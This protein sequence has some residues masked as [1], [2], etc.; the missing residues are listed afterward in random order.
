MRSFISKIKRA[1]ALWIAVAFGA[2][3]MA[4]ELEDFISPAKELYFPVPIYV[5]DMAARH[6]L[7]T[8]PKINS[9]HMLKSS[10]RIVTSFVILECKYSP[11]AKPLLPIEQKVSRG[12]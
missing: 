3:V 12:M 2:G 10:T 6:G 5:H 7:P 8:C 11:D 4:A 1:R 9:G